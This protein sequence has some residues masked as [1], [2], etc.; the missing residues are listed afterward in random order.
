MS[1][2]FFLSE[3][4]DATST[5]MAMSVSTLGKVILQLQTKT[6][7]FYQVEVPQIILFPLMSSAAVPCLA[8][9]TA[10]RLIADVVT[11]YC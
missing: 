6:T 5:T 3:K 4:P 7:R 9:V 11:G 8:A 1:V 2:L 10:P